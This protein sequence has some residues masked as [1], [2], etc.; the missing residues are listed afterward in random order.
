MRV[1]SWKKFQHF[2]DRRP[3]WIKLYRD[4]L[5]DPDWHDL[6]G[7][8]AKGLVMLWLIASENEGGLP[9]PRKLS[10]RL[11]ITEAKVVQLLKR[12]KHWIDHEDTDLISSGHQD[13]APEREGETQDKRQTLVVDLEF[14]RFKKAYPKRKGSQGWPTAQKFFYLAA[15]AGCPAADL[16]AAASKFEASIARDRIGTEFVPMAE[17][18]M[19]K[20]NWREF[21]PT[22]EDREKE[23]RIAEFMRTKGKIWVEG[24]G[25]VDAAQ[26][27][28]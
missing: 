10:F 23:A 4:L 5:D 12:L 8:D 28:T 19:R 22:N 7:D 3:P 27:E 25:W 14:E 13:D 9:S 26:N 11:R 16:T 6:D 2:R 24:T 17:T 20:G 15:H 18:W 21:M 1:K